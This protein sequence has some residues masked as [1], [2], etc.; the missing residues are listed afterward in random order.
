MTS[1]NAPTLRYP[2]L[3]FSLIFLLIGIWKHQNQPESE[4]EVFT[5]SPEITYIEG[6]A[7]IYTPPRGTPRILITDQLGERYF[8]DCLVNPDFCIHTTRPQSTTISAQLIKLKNNAYWPLRARFSNGKILGPEE[9]Q[10]I[11]EI[12]NERESS[13]YKFWLA[14]SAALAIFSFWFGKRPLL[15]KEEGDRK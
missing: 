7:T 14:I 2:L 9:S 11:Y 15:G 10:I 12:F 1:K 5:N 13:F 4:K 8:I 6:S 3:A